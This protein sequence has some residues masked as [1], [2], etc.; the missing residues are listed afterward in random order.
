VGVT[1]LD[2]PR[3]PTARHHVTLTA[4][5]RWWDLD[6]T[7]LVRD[8]DPVEALDVALADRDLLPLLQPTDEPSVP[9]TPVAAPLGLDAL[10]EPGAIGLAL[11]PPDLEE[12]LGIAAAGRSLPPKTT[13][14]TPKLRSGLVVTP[15][16]LAA[17]AD[18]PRDRGSPPYAPAR[19]RRRRPRSHPA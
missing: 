11:H 5:G 9:A 16:G 2:G 18:D 14:V 4:V 10:V 12:V 3:A 19:G 1:A 7:A 13:Y 8:D 15:R 6:V 17:D